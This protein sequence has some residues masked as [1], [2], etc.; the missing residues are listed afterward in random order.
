M[1]EVIL[2]EA[3]ASWPRRFEREA[4]ALRRWLPDDLVLAIDHIGS[5]AIA[6]MPAKPIIDILLTVPDLEQARARAVPLLA[7]HGYLFWAENPRTDRLFFVKGLPP[8]AVARTHH[9]HVTEPG[10]EALQ[11]IAF[12][13][14]LRS[15]HAEAARYAALKRE[16]ARSHRTD[17]EA[18][19]DAKAAF[20]AEILGKRR[21][22]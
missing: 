20:V 10:G 18:Y 11:T 7:P 13:D 1:D 21:G 9:L 16:L 4:A 12:R 6:G 22:G 15:H 2:M 17:R 3:D 5:T 8:A 14:H 19:T